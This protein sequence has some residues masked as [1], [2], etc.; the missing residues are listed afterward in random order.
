MTRRESGADLKKLFAATR[1]R[2]LA[3]AL[4]RPAPDLAL[5]AMGDG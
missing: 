1:E 3:T 4:Y 2:E 5:L